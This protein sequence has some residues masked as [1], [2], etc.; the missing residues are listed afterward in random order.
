MS[1]ALVKLVH[2]GCRSLGL[3]EETR[4]EL[5]LVVT[6]KASL[7]EMTDGEIARVVDALKARGFQPA[8]PGAGGKRKAHPA[9]PRAD[10]R[11]VHAL[12]SQLGRAGAVRQPG[13]SGLNAFIRARFAK[14]WGA[15]PADIDMLRDWSQIRDVIDALK[16]MCRRAGVEVRP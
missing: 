14:K 9:A 6:G 16:D 12:W 10:L 5:Q 4:R 11:L 2:V 13:R 3:D 15:V 8:A 7:A 1:R